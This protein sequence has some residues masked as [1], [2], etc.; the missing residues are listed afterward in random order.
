MN[1]HRSMM[2]VYVKESD[3]ALE[4]YK[5]AFGAEVLCVH[6]DE[7]GKLIMHAELNVYGQVLAISEQMNNDTIAGNSMQFCLHLG[8]GKEDEV[9]KIYDTL[10]DSA[11]IQYPL[12]PCDWSTLMIGLID[13]FGVNWCVFV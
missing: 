1:M 10:K 11:E 4:F 8:D 5:K 3:K 9:R 6:T 7:D 13:K 12:S 2:Q